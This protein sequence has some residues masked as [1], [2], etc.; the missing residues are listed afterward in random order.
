MATRMEKTI[1]IEH[2]R[3]ISASSSVTVVAAY[4]GL[5][6]EKLSSLRKS[7][8]GNGGQFTVFKNTL[9]KIGSG[10]T[11][12]GLLVQEM[13]G[14]VGYAFS[15]E[16]PMGVIK[17]LVDFSKVNP[18]FEIRAGVLDGQKVTYQELVQLSNVPDRKV[19]Y[20]QLLGLI[21]SPLSN[22]VGGLQQ[23]LRKSLYALE[24]RKKQIDH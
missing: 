6:V 2:F 5:N 20:G 12:A 3:K 23:I 13:K 4:K 11:D 24:E 18:L 14:Q 7:L 1:K 8:K 15:S 17:T 21:G 10:S 22:F 9:S 16:N 19:L